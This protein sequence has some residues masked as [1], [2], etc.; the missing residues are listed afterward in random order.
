[1]TSTLSL[2]TLTCCK[3]AQENNCVRLPCLQITTRLLTKLAHSF[4]LLRL[5]ANKTTSKS[6]LKIYWGLS[7]P[8]SA[9]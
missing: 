2:L 4:S 8:A 9:Y 7:L 5:R 6:C 3:N 1:M